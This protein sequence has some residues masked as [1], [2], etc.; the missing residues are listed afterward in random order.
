MKRRTFIWTSSVATIAILLPFSNCSTEPSFDEIIANP[1]SL[2]HIYN[3]EN[4]HKIGSLYMT[5]VSGETNKH[6]LK[7]LILKNES[8][9]K[10]S[11][12]FNKLL[13]Q[14]SIRKKIKND[15]IVGSTIIIDGWI[16]SKTEVRQCALFSLINS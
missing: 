6:I 10:P 12:L 13:V 2:A 9:K 7:N 11:K 15:F 1:I 8:E 4:I 14:N 5:L 16:L 3:S